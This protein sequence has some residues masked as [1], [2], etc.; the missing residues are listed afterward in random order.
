MG[1]DLLRDELQKLQIEYR[2]ILEQASKNIYQKESD[3]IIDEINIF[4]YKNKKLIQCILRYLHKPYSAYVFTAAT[5]MDLDDYEHYP[6]VSL[7]KYHL[8]DDPICKYAEVARKVD[9]PFGQKLREQ[10]I[11][12]INDNIK[13]LDR[14]SEIIYILPIRLLSD[15]DAKMLHNAAQNVFLSMFKENLNFE[16]YRKNFRTISDIKNG[17]LSGVEKSIV[18]S[19]EDDNTLDLE[20]RFRN[21]KE[22]TVLPLSIEA[23]DA[24]VFWFGIYGY[25]LQVFDI[26][27]MCSEYQLIPY[28]RFK[29]AIQYI[30]M[31]Y[32]NYRNNQELKDMMFKC[33]IAHVLHITFDKEKIFNINFREYYQTIQNYN[34]ENRLFSDLQ[35]KK[36]SLS[37]LTMKRVVPIIDRNFESFMA[38][39]NEDK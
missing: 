4:W 33:I 11:S 23:T 2:N 38:K 12:T 17:L 5:I 39:Y 26:L 6:F 15:I 37:N 7:G 34:F 22:Y 24:E 35:N 18:F 29:V 21:Y 25:I 14:A 28:I 19:E 3:A 16:N 20:T 36:I 1:S 30:L 13:I 27:F 8:W 31:I 10:I 32:P 9:N